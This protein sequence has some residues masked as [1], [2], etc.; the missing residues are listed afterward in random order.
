VKRSRISMGLVLVLAVVAISLLWSYGIGSARSARTQREASARSATPAQQLNSD[1]QASLR[2][3]I[4]ARK[5]DQTL[6]TACS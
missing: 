1:S 6:A 2:A 5:I 3:I 4:Q